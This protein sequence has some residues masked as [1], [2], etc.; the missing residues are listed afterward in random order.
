[1][2]KKW[3]KEELVEHIKVNLD[4]DYGMAIVCGAL[5]KKLYGEYPKLGLSGFQAGG[6]DALMKV[7]PDIDQPQVSAISGPIEANIKSLKGPSE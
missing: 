1:M 4:S 7:I 6:I 5:Y 2:D 3:T